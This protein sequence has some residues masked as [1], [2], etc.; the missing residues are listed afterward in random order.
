MNNKN[1]DCVVLFNEPVATIV[2]LPS[3]KHVQRVVYVGV[4]Q[5]VGTNSIVHWTFSTL[6]KYNVTSVSRTRFNDI[7]ILQ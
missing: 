1:E 3:N 2:F 4:Q 5:V 6:I 7:I